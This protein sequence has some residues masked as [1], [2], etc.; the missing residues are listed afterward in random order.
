MHQGRAEC[1]KD[2]LVESTDH[3]EGKLELMFTSMLLMLE[4][5]MMGILD[6]R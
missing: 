2:N 4:V 6:K 3:F 5:E 1:V